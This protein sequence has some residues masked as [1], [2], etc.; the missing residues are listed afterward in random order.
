MKIEKLHFEKKEIEIKEVYIDT[1]GKVKERIRMVSVPTGKCL[2]NETDNE[3][4]N[5]KSME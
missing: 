4:T 3:K 5:N 1:D 2:D